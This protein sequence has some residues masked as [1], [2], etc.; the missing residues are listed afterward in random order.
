MG[1]EEELVGR[2]LGKVPGAEEEF[3][4]LYQAR[5]L[6]ASR[7]FLGGQDSEADDIVQEAFFIAFPKLKDYVFKAP[8][9]AWLRQICLRLSYA[10][11]RA[12]K[13]V[14]VSLEEDLEMYLRRLAAERVQAAE[15]EQQK[16]G[17][18]QLLER[19]KL[20]LGPDSARIIQL[21]DVQGLSYLMISRALAVP[22]GTVMSRL[23]RSRD[24]LR[25]LVE[26]EL[27]TGIEADCAR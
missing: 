18:L 11:L 23:A 15:L 27:L 1:T 21:R 26:D 16:Q 24:Q 6:R 3:F 12:R 7:Y 8:I 9:Y 4:H 2:I 25:K 20:R 5:L 22:M 19:L 17:R 13:R 10:R 14:L